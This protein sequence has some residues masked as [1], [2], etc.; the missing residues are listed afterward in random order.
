MD[1]TTIFL[2]TTWSDRFYEEDKLARALLD[3]IP[4]AIL[5]TDLQSVILYANFQAVNMF[6]YTEEELLGAEIE[7]LIPERFR[8]NH[9][10]M[11]KQYSEHPMMRPMGRDIDLYGVTKHDRE[12]FVDICLSPINTESGG[13]ILAAVRDISTLKKIQKE[14]TE[15]NQRLSELAFFDSLTQLSNRKHFHDMLAREMSRAERHD[16]TLALLYIDLDSFKPVNDEHGHALGDKLLIKVGE[17]LKSI[18]RQEDFI[19]RI[20]GDEFVMLISDIADVDGASTVAQKV[21]D[22]L[23]RPFEIEHHEIQIGA[24]IGISFYPQHASSIE[25]F[26]KHADDAMY[27]AK[28]HGKNR[29]E[30][31]Q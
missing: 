2:E 28:K 18:S 7:I 11:R 3:F 26:I 9:I 30:I 31:H 29:F 16:I 17:R 27:L 10:E 25:G 23:N 24:S 14:L 13:L 5:I 6:E 21:I 20:G 8:K 1:Q 19:A 22:V 4:D 15:T 12:F